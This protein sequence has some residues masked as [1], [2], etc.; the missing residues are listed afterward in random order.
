M[1]MNS[2]AHSLTLPHTMYIYIIS[3]TDI[4]RYKLFGAHI[5][6]EASRRNYGCPEN[7]SNENCLA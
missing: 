2:S 4:L 7:H 3:P 6:I 1:K 5:K